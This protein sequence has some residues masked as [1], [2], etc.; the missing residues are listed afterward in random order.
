MNSLY[1]AAC[2]LIWTS[3]EVRNTVRL[4]IEKLF[5]AEAHTSLTWDGSISKTKPSARNDY[6]E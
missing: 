6:R 5:T 2:R 1:T 3:A 4:F